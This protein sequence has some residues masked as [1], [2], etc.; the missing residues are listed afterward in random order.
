M[1]SAA[2]EAAYERAFLEARHDHGALRL[3][4]QVLRNPPVRCVHHLLKHVGRFHQ[5]LL[6]LRLGKQQAGTRQNQHR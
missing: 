6:M 2:L 4:E 5:T 1:N 3:V